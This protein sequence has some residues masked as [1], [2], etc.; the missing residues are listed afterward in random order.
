MC[1]CVHEPESREAGSRC[2][3]LRRPKQPAP[4]PFHQPINNSGTGPPD[5]RPLPKNQ[6]RPQPG[7]QGG[8]VPLRGGHLLHAEPGSRFVANQ[9]RC[10]VQT[11]PGPFEPSRWSAPCT[12]GNDTHATALSAADG[13]LPSTR[14][15]P[16]S[17]AP[18]PPQPAR[19][20]STGASRLRWQRDARRYRRP[21][22][23][24]A[25]PATKPSPTE[26]S[27]PSNCCR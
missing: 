9:H 16:C 22:K 7:H 3:L 20:D 1:V 11:A 14:P 4:L 19:P 2:G 12:A 17:T 15:P 8:R 5:E 18:W 6:G 10:D 26:A 13:G 21:R 23:S 27:A 24:A 25:T